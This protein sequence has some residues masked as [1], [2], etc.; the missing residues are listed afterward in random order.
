MSAARALSPK[1]NPA[2]APTAIAMTFFIAPAISHPTTSGFVYTRN[3][4]G[5]EQLLQLLRR[6]RHRAVATTDAVGWPSA[7]SR[8]RLGPVSTAIVSASTRGNTA[9]T[10]WLMRA[11]VPCSMPLVRL[12][13]SVSSAIAG[14]ARRPARRGTR[15]KGPP[16]RRRRR[17]CTPRARSAVARRLLVERDPRQVPRVL[18]AARRSRRPAPGSRPQSTTSAFA[19]QRS[20]NAVPHDPAPITASRVTNALRERAIEHGR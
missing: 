15:A 5:H 18:V 12:T 6:R 20:A 3:V 9:S 7:I 4:C 11:S 2:A 10:T 17:R 19:Q 13:T 1:P 16:S 8:T 14:A